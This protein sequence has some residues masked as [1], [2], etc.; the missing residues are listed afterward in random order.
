MRFLLVIFKRLINHYLP[1]P[2]SVYKSLHVCSL[3]TATNSSQKRKKRE[4]RDVLG[5]D[6][7]TKF[8][9]RTSGRASKNL[10]LVEVKG[11]EQK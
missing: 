10:I 1:V 6:G 5:V 3:T 8:D 2:N 11:E 7:K 4:T 9:F